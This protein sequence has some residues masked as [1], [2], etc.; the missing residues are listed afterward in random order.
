MNY[1]NHKYN[2]KA[3]IVSPLS[4]GQGEEKDW[5]EGIDYITRDGLLY[6]LDTE[7]MPDMDIDLEILADLFSKGKTKA[8]DELI[9]DDLEEV[10]DFDLRIPA[11]TQNPI[12]TFYFNPLIGKYSLLGSSLKGAIR[13]ALFHFLTKNESADNLRRRQRLNE[14]VF[15]S[16]KYGTDFMRFIRV[17]DFDFD[18]TFLVNTKIYN[19]QKQGSQWIGGWKHSAKNTSKDFMK[20]GFNT[21]YE[22]LIPGKQSEGFIMISPLLFEKIKDRQDYYR[23]K[24][25][26]MSD[27]ERQSPLNSLFRIINS[28]T[29]EYLEKEIAF[30]KAFPQGD[31]SE[32]ILDS[33]SQY[34]ELLSSFPKDN[35]S[36]CLLK[37]S[38]GTGF[39]SITGDWQF[40][41]YSQTG[42]YT[43]GRNFGKMRYKS[44]KIACFNNQFSPMGFIK[45]SLVSEV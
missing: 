2:V 34:E 30:F 4:I 3:T 32:L 45:L 10:S 5:V 37:M 31:Y 11:S 44:R 17:G 42:E 6:H 27:T 14:S 24:S 41:D 8:I 15:G 20:T 1:V 36:D 40:D 26:L 12:K 28:T 21:V 35:P 39:H 43:F 19:L 29:F 38:V 9:G 33:L 18:N 13:S 7:L 16:M 22:C 23:E 25:T